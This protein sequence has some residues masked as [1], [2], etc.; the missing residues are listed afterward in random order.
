M[1][2]QFD[3]LIR[4]AHLR[5]MTGNLFQIGIVHGRIAAIEKSMDGKAAVEIN[6]QG[7]LVSG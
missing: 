5:D 6:A 3:I 4:N 1:P 2:E 7:N